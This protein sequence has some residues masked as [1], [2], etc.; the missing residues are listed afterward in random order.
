MRTSGIEIPFIPASCP[1]CGAIWQSVLTDVVSNFAGY[2]L[3]SNSEQCP[4]CGAIGQTADGVFQVIAG[5]I[6]ILSGPSVT[7]EKLLILKNVLAEERK[8][9]SNP[10]ELR[11][12]VEQI[13]STFSAL[14]DVKSWSPSVKA[15]IITAIGAVIVALLLNNQ[16][17]SGNNILTP[18]TVINN[19]YGLKS[20]EILD[21]QTKP[22]F[23]IPMAKPS[24]R[25]PN[26]AER[27][28]QRSQRRR[29]KPQS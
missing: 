8:N 7:Y 22:T 10:Q 17:P 9:L 6:S 25:E 20:D 18:I 29:H 4:A 28:R 11:Q 26:R 19:V 24:K 13:D 15:S 2:E 14:F 16:A 1:N 3:S 12:K 23:L 27:R 5:A 21:A